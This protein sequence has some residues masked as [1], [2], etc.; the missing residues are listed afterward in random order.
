MKQFR[1]IAWLPLLAAALL[2]A[3]CASTRSG[4]HERNSNYYSGS[5]GRVTGSRA[6]DAAIGGTA[7]AIL[8]NQVGRGNG[9]T[10]ATAAGAATGA[11]IASGCDIGARR[12]RATL[13]RFTTELAECQ[14]GKTNS[15]QNSRSAS[16]RVPI[17]RFS[18]AERPKVGR[19][20][21]TRSMPDRADARQKTAAEVRDR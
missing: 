20:V 8:G 7:G 1:T 6:A 15:V 18:R 11:A 5:G 12:G 4:N 14:G 2:A 16:H 10:V 17:A 21:V 13:A 19:S 3:G 9:Q